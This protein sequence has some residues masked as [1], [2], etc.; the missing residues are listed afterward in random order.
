M[1]EVKTHRIG[2][3]LAGVLLGAAVVTMATAPASAGI[4]ASVQIR[5]DVRADGLSIGA[6]VTLG[7]TTPATRRD[8]MEA[9]GDDP[10]HQPVRLVDRVRRVVTALRVTRRALRC[11]VASWW[12]TLHGGL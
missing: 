6:D 12:H 1:R 2:R 10:A 11:V 5:L 3:A 7:A 8:V 9:R 4:P